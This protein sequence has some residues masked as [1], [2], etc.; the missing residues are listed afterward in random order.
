MIEEMA[1]VEG[2]YWE[3]TLTGFKWLGTKAIEL[4]ER[5]FR[6]LMAYEE[7]IGLFGL[8]CRIYG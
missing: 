2:I 1:R 6:V 5:G 7:A 3:E 4:R 8:K